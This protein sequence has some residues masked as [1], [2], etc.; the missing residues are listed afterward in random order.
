MTVNCL[1][2]TCKQYQGQV[3]GSWMGTMGVGTSGGEYDGHYKHH[4]SDSFVDKDIF[5]GVSFQYYS[6]L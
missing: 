1:A 2:S 5:L 6:V 4:V 3:P